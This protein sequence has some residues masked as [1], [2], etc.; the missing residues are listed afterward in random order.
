MSRIS[1]VSTFLIV[2]L[3]NTYADGQ[4]SQ[5]LY[6]NAVKELAKL[7]PDDARYATVRANVIL[8]EGQF[9]SL[10]RGMPL[11][12][13]EVILLGKTPKD[14]QIKLELKLRRSGIK[15]ERRRSGR[16]ANPSNAFLMVQ[17]NQ[18]HSS[19]W[20]ASL[21]VTEAVTLSRPNSAKILCVTYESRF[22]DCKTQDEAEKK[23]WAALDE[24]CLLYMKFSKKSDF[25]KIQGKWM[26]VEFHSLGEK[27][28]FKEKHTFTFSGKKLFVLGGSYEIK[29]GE[30]AFELGPDK[31]PRE[32]DVRRT[33]GGIEPLIYE[34]SG[35]TLKICVN[36][37]LAGRPKKIGPPDDEFGQMMVF[38]RVKGDK[39]DD[40]K[41]P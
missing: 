35:D 30:N 11:V 33:G 32:M 12:T 36:S 18:L 19:L 10:F 7:T 29:G 39:N 20:Y 40:K 21:T 27:L 24:F 14:S 2:F 17:V 1:I 34:L 28:T 38:K 23:M 13:P 6:H 5:F 31:K 9:R 3:S 37:G 41:K 22:P 25:D 16:G 26:I 15:L 4:V 8:Y